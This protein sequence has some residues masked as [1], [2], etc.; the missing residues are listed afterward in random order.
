MR[1]KTIFCLIKGGEEGEGATIVRAP[2]G[3]ITCG[4][5]LLDV[6]QRDGVTA[7]GLR[8]ISVDVPRKLVR[9]NNEGENRVR[10]LRKTGVV[11]LGG[12]LE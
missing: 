11:I 12:D 4:E 8:L 5:V 7:E 1:I 2:A 6:A 9:Q 10:I 3:L